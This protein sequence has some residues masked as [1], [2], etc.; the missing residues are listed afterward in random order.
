MRL[1][2]NRSEVRMDMGM[3]NLDLLGFAVLG[4]Q[5]FNELAQ[6][7]RFTDHRR[8]HAEICDEHAKVSARAHGSRSCWFEEGV[9]HHC[10]I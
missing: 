3:G 6:Q 4:F 8:K 9:C 1:G 2:V 10:G 7:T 5:S